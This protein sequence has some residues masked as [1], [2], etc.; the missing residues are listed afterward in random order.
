MKK[1]V[2]WVLNASLTLGW[3]ITSAESVFHSGCSC[4][5]TEVEGITRR[6]KLCESLGMVLPSY[7][8]LWYNIFRNLK[9]YLP[10]NSFIKGFMIS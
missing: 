8:L 2:R 3:T 4:I 1:E 5:K 7:F 10:I 6:G 9:G